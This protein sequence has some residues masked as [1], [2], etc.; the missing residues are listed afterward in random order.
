MLCF[1][2]QVYNNAPCR[3]SNLQNACLAMLVFSGP[4]RSGV[5]VPGVRVTGEGKVMDVSPLNNT[6]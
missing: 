6:H 1:C 4:D 2:A 5:E 3:M